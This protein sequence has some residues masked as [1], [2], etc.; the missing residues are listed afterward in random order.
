MYIY[1]YLFILFYIVYTYKVIS[2]TTTTT[3]EK[4]GIA[5]FIHFHV[6]VKKPILLLNQRHSIDNNIFKRRQNG[7][8]L[9]ESYQSSSHYIHDYT[10]HKNAMFALYV[11]Q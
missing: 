7:N 9:V 6:I 10:L 11:Y 1:M 3:R 5:N 2:N 8:A 4:S